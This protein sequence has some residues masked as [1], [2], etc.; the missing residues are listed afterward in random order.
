[1]TGK[2]EICQRKAGKRPGTGQRQNG[3]PARWNR[4][5]VPGRKENDMNRN[6]WKEREAVYAC[7]L[8][9]FPDMGN[10]QLHRLTELCGGP[11]AAYLADKEKWGQVLN[12]RQVQSLARYTAAWKPEAEYRKMKEQ[13]IRLVTMGDEGYPRRLKD[14]PDAPYGLF[15]RGRLQ[16]DDAPAVAV[17]GARECSEYGRYVAK[18]LGA[19]LGRRGITVVSG[20]AR[21]IDG[22]SQEAALE[23]GG[24]SIGVLGS[25]VDVCYP[26]QNRPIYERLIRTGAVLSTYPLGM[27]ALPRNFPPRNRIV[28]GLA[29]AVVVVEARAKS[30]T[31]IT[32]DMALEQ[33]R[34]VYIVPGRVTDRLSDGCNR[35]VKQGA[36]IVLSPE[37][38]LEEIWQL[39]ERGRKGT[40]A[41]RQGGLAVPKAP[42]APEAGV[43]PEADAVLEESRTA[44]LPEELA[45]VA[46]V[47]D[48]D[49][50]SPE[51]ICQHLS[52]KSPQGQY[53]EKQIVSCLM[54]LCME[55][56]A[57]QVSP[58]RFCCRRG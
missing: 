14:I 12:P 42:E 43:V 1:M 27:P 40:A 34:E 53:P 48:F 45:Q 55:G 50:K 17:I 2:S 49:P 18:C 54:Q 57:V 41:G 23:A 46:G 37:S 44:G 26:A 16:A 28:S 9:N 4:S 31:L 25:G 52:E 35:L 13:G 32:V 36:G 39:W 8:C 11:E 22:I 58:G 15:V 30:G 47:L 56:L 51:E 10:K 38:F 19:T 6:E 7:W 21:G 20:M 24:N 33:G 5:A 29:D 3:A